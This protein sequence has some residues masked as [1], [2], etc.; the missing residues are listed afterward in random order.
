MDDIKNL[1]SCLPQDRR[2]PADDCA[3]EILAGNLYEQVENVS[4]DASFD[5]F[6]DSDLEDINDQDEDVEEKE[7]TMQDLDRADKVFEEALGMKSMLKN[8]VKLV[9]SEKILPKEILCQ[10]LCY[11]IQ[12]SMKGSQSVRYLVEYGMFWAS[13]RNL[14]KSRGLVAFKEH[15][16]IPSNLSKFKDKIL[17]TCS[18]DKK[19]LGKSGLQK[20]NINLWIKE[21]RQEAEDKTLGVSIAIDGKKI[22][23]TSR[24]EED[25]GDLSGGKN[26]SDEEV[27]HQENTTELMKL[28]DSLKDRNCCFMLY[29]KLTTETCKLVFKLDTIK[30][31]LLKNSKQLEK[32]SNLAKYIYVLNQQK[33]TGR[34]LI[35]I[36]HKIQAELIASISLIRK[37]EDFIPDLVSQSVN[38]DDQPNY[39]QL[40]RIDEKSEDVACRKIDRILGNVADIFSAPWDQLKQV[41]GSLEKVS[42][43]S[44]V[45]QKIFQSSYLTDD[46]VFHACGLGK[47]RPL[48]EMKEIYEAVHS[49]FVRRAPCTKPNQIVVATLT[50]IFAPLTFGRNMVLRDGGLFVRNGLCSTPDLVVMEEIGSPRIEFCVKIFPVESQTFKVKEEMVVAAIASSLIVDAVRGCLVVLCSDMSCVVYNVP[51]TDSLAERCLGFIDSYLKKPKCLTRR[52]KEMTE[53]IGNIQIDI[54]EAKM[55]VKTLGSYPLVKSVVTSGMRRQSQDHILKPIDR[56]KKQI[57]LKDSSLIKEDLSGFLEGSRKFLAK[58]ARELVVVN[59]SDMSGTNSKAP[60]TLLAATYL[61]GSSLKTIVKECF[62]SVTKFLEDKEVN[63]LNYAVDGESLHLATTLSDGSPG[64]DLSLAKGVLKKLKKFSKAELVKLVSENEGINLNSAD[65]QNE[66]VEEGQNVASQEDVLMQVNES[67]VLNPIEYDELFTL[68][69]LEIVLRDSKRVEKTELIN[70]EEKCKAMKIFDLRVLCLRQVFPSLKSKWLAMNYGS[71][72]VVVQLETQKMVYSP[73]TVFEKNQKNVFKTITF[74]TAHLSNLLREHAAKGKL[75]ELG[76]FDKSLQNLS[77]VSDFSYLKKIISL[78]NGS[79]EYDP[80]NQASSAK[81]FSKK[82]EAGLLKL[83]DSSGAK[84]CKVLREGIIESLDSSGIRSMERCRLVF[85]LKTFL[86]EKINTLD[87]LKRPGSLEMTA[88]LLQMIY[89]SLDSHIVSYLNIE[90]FNTRRKS[91]GSVEQFF[92]QIT[93][94]SDGGMKLNCAVLT[95]ILERVTITNA[96]RMLPVSVKGFSFLKYLKVHMKSYT[97]KDDDEQ[98]AKKSRYPIITSFERKKVVHPIDSEFDKKEG[99][100]RKKCENLRETKQTTGSDGGVRKFHRKFS[101]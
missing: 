10:A 58:Q 17:E 87:K 45:F 41:S 60:H 38:L 24:G 84:V 12:R 85:N 82:T 70:R 36:L 62:L 90:F 72:S 63:V 15:F 65:T 40:A 44:L 18:L 33:A 27:K 49:D 6:S 2:E 71:S 67:I 97:D 81:L 51:R 26:A 100:K 53:E 78:K 35:E 92:S 79:L 89:C 94:M 43:E 22:A 76:L 99:T 8:L 20:S 37:C 5:A 74:D 39:Y 23:A 25:L 64:T 95:D 16:P 101:K 1:R 50:A 14:L 55:E 80:M 31:L 83:G 52:S 77:K 68:E 54:K 48:G 34:E 28:I 98:T 21:K 69:D 96:L 66:E 4:S 56:P 32:N 57:K 29:D 19:S 93:L 13:I 42:R 88:E 91:T 3:S 59:I 47:Q 75:S 86:E 11:K 73:N 46:Q 9:L 61:T 30:D 7:I